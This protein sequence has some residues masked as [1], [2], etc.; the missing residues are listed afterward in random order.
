MS[1]F[2]SKVAVVTGSGA[3]MGRATALLLAEEGGRVVVA[4]IDATKGEETAR[5]INDAGGEAIFCCTDIT[6]PAQTDPIM[7]GALEAFGHV[8]IVHANAGVNLSGNSS[9]MIA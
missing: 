2:D 8:D 7:A 9:S 3:G 6:D 5:L 4:D 1:R